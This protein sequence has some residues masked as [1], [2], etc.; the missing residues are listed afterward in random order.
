MK[1]R[2]SR[3]VVVAETTDGPL[4]N[5]EFIEVSAEELMLKLLEDP[6]LA[7]Y[8]TDAD[9]VVRFYRGLELL[10]VNHRAVNLW[11]K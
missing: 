8:S 9:N 5:L 3:R 2:I 6:D 11:N 1:Y 4:M 10:A 7:Y